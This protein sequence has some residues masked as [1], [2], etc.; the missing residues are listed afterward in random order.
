MVEARFTWRV[1]VTC[2]LVYSAFCTPYIGREHYAAITLAERGSLNVE[3]Y[4]GWT[5]DLFRAPRGGAYIN[6]NPGASLA[7][8][9]PL[10][11]LRPLLARVDQWNQARPRTIPK[12]NGNGRMFAR[13]VPAGREFYFLLVAFLTVALVMA[14]ATAGAAALLCSSLARAGVPSASSAMAAMLCGLGTPLLYRTG[15]LNHNLLVAD[16]GLAALLLLWDPAA[17]PLSAVRA[18]AAGLLAGFSL[19]CDYSGVVVIGVS[20]LYAWMRSA[21]YEG[22]ERW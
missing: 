5:E 19:L 11:L 21:D 14:P 22:P 15:Y 9:V 18:A 6:N 20:A 10:V 1:F 8:A 4:L 16:A 3:P 17:K 7:G 2:W 13:T 12:G